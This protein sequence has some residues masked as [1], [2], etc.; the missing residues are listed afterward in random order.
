MQ[1]DL[2]ARGVCKLDVGSRALQQLHNLLR[3]LFLVTAEKLAL[4][5]F[6]GQ[7]ERQLVLAFPVPLI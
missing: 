3:G 5:T 1:I 4:R 6:E 7:A 2:Q